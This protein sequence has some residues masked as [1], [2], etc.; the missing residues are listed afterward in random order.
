MVSNEAVSA[1]MSKSPE[2][3]IMAIAGLVGMAA[4]RTAA[5]IGEYGGDFSQLLGLCLRNPWAIRLAVRAVTDAMSR[6][7]EKAVP[8]SAPVPWE[9]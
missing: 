6:F 8:L 2:H 3:N 1:G 9:R 7:P 5:H 4:N